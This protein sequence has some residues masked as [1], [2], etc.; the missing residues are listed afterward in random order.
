LDFSPSFL[1]AHPKSFELSTRIAQL[2][3]QGIGKL[4]FVSSGSEAVDTAMKICL[5][6]QRAVGAPAE[7][8]DLRGQRLDDRRA[9]HA[10]KTLTGAT[11]RAIA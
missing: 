7:R 2:L 1:R 6:Y 11:V 5:A 4:F 9:L 3:P 8:L 10:R